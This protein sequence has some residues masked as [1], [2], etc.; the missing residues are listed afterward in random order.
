MPHLGAYR[1]RIRL[2]DVEHSTWLEI[3]GLNKAISR[4]HML[5][6]DDLKALFYSEPIP[7][8]DREP[9]SKVESRRVYLHTRVDK[10]GFIIGAKQRIN[11]E[12][13]RTE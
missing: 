4:D 9:G 12:R 1:T 11:A 3:D 13:L 7:I 2:E 8:A 10:D 5:P 6:V